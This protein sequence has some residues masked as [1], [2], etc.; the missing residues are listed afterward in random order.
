MSSNYVKDIEEMHQ[1]YKIDISS[2][3]KVKLKAF[4]KFRADLIKEELDE[5]YKAIEDEN[6]EE[7]VDAFID[8]NVVSVGSL[9]LLKV[10]QVKAWDSVLVANMAKEPGIK[11]ER[12][13]PLGL[14]DL[15]KP[16][17]WTPPSHAGNYGFLV[18]LND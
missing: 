12:P 18:K 11:P 7:I 9:D 2:F 10:D 14:P 1:H 16:E 17:G 5:L 13:N 15:I 3:D 4:L 6:A 8:I